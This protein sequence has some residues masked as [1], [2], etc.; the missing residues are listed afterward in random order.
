MPAWR[1]RGGEVVVVSF[2]PPAKMKQFLAIHPLPFRTVSDPDRAAYRA[3][4]LGRT[5][6]LAFL[7]PDVLWRYLKGIAHGYGPVKPEDDDLLQ[8]GGDFL[9]DATGRLVWSRP[10]REPTDRPTAAELQAAMASAIQ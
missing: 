2:T 1:I 8:L 9:I 4:S 6:V 10:S 3:L 7:R 5:S